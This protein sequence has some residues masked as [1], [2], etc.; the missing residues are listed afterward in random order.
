MNDK[1]AYQLPG[2]GALIDEKYADGDEEKELT[3]L[4]LLD[5]EP[6]EYLGTGRVLLRMRPE[7]F[8]ELEPSAVNGW[9]Q[10]TFGSSGPVKWER[11][12]ALDKPYRVCIEIQRSVEV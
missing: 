1:L 9:I 10:T 3:V 5:S 4:E 7:D 8:D 6:I 11:I 2:D 12:F